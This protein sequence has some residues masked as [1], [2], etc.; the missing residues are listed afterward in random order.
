MSITKR[1]VAM[2]VV[3]RR[4]KIED[5]RQVGGEVFVDSQLSSHREPEAST[6][7]HPPHEPKKPKLQV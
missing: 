6:R 2:L 4:M 5:F 3:L 7:K 1:A